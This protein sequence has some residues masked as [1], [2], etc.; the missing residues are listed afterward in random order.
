MVTPLKGSQKKYLRGLAHSMNPSA[1]VGHKGI[2]PALMDEINQALGAAELIKIKFNDHKEKEA[3]N[4][5]IEE[6]TLGTHS[7]LAGMV[8]HVAILFRRNPDPEKQK[9]KLP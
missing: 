6:I 2:T 4:A 1:M 3:K 9:I 7:Q 8:G 5:L